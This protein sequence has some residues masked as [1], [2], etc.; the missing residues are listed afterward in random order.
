MAI[1]AAMPR[2]IGLNRRLARVALAT[3]IGGAILFDGSASSAQRVG[4]QRF[5]PSSSEDGVLGTE[6]ADRRRQLEPY[7][8]LWLAYT[9]DPVVVTDN[10]GDEIGAVVDHVLSAH[11]AASINL[12][13]GLEVGL[14]MPVSLFK[15]GDDAVATQLGIDDQGG[16]ALGD[17]QLRAG[18]RFYLSYR[19]HLAIH[20]GVLLPTSPA[21]DVLSLGFGVRPT[22]AF[23][24]G[25]DFMDLLFNV[26]YLYRADE[27]LADF[28]GGMELGARMAARIGL[29]ETWDTSVVAEV[30]M[31]TQLADFFGPAGTPVEAR[32]G[33]EHW[34]S[35]HW[36]VGAFGGAGIGPGVGAPDFRVGLHIAYGTQPRRPRIEPLPGDEDADGIRDEDDEC[37]YD[38]EDRDGFEDDDGCPDEDNDGDGILDVDDACPNE[39]ES[40]DGIADDDGCPDRIR[41]EGSLITTFEPVQFRSESAEILRESHPMLREVASVMR[42]NPDMDIRVEGHTD[43]TGDDDYNMRLSQQRAESVR[44]FIISQGIDGSRIE[45]EGHGETRPI[46]SNDTAEGRRQNRR[47]EFHIN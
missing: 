16:T 10:G 7:L 5:D 30:G 14:A 18:Y 27:Q 34:L 33:L 19:A 17:L 9:N 40:M 36:R 15:S 32:G 2:A 42:A 21:G 23:L 31:S 45:A 4:G 41:V 25:F 44:R 24:Y 43:S 8:A 46:A 37:P 1:I 28:D 13:A 39:P 35:R 12:V 29:D 6:G 26:S 22:L 11:L 20:L 38:P 3:F 47:V